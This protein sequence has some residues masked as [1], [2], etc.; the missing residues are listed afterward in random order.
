MSLTYGAS[1]VLKTVGLNVPPSQIMG[2]SVV[3]GF[4]VA[5]LVLLIL[6]WLNVGQVESNASSTYTP[7]IAKGVKDYI[8]LSS[9]FNL[10]TTLTFF[11]LLY[12]LLGPQ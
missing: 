6:A 7:V 3:I 2:F 1:G 11:A 12:L 10:T 8:T 9:W 5:S 4:W